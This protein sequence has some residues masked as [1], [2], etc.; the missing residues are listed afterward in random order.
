MIFSYSEKFHIEIGDN[1][2]LAYVRRWYS[3]HTYSNH[4]GIEQPGNEVRSKEMDILC[5]YFT[6]EGRQLLKLLV[7][8]V[9]SK[10]KH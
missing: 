1:P 8:V 9:E 3:L 7:C 5:D 6:E 4:H 10:T 2:Y